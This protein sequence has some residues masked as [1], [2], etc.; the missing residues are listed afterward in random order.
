MQF[1]PLIQGWL[2]IR[3]SIDIIHHRHIIKDKYHMI[4]T[5]D[6][7]QIFGKL[8]HPFMLRKEKPQEVGKRDAF[9]T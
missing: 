6:A 9:L 8:Q 5:T 7:K 2:Y 4:K 3:N 1:I